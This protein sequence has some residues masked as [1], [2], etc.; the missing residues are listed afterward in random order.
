MHSAPAARA[1]ASRSSTAAST[2]R[3]RRSSGPGT[4]AAYEAAWAPIPPAGSPTIPVLT[5]GG[6][7]VVDDPATNADNGLFPSAK[8][9]GGYDF[10]GEL[11]ARHPC[12]AATAVAGS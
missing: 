12:R 6:Y 10:V 7:L 5:S 11:L 2:T 8:V 1:C 3:T 9:V 4:K